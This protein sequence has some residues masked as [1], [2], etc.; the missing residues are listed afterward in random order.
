LSLLLVLLFLLN[1]S[2]SLCISHHS[3]KTSEQ[4]TPSKPAHPSECAN[5]DDVSIVIVYLHEGLGST[6]S[7][8][9]AIAVQTIIF[10]KVDLASWKLI[11]LYSWCDVGI[12]ILPFDEPLNSEE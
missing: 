3:P 8:L 11:F 10:T 9:S 7:I 6:R 5:E 4:S 2:F 1:F 12:I